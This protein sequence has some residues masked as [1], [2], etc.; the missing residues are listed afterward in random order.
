MLMADM[1]KLPNAEFDIMKVVWENDP[2]ITTKMILEQL[3]H[4]RD[5]KAQTVISLMLR[6][7]ERGFLRTEK[8]GKERTFYPLIERDAYLEFETSNFVNLYH[9]NS[10]LHLVNTMY[11]GKALSDADIDELLQWA[12]ERSE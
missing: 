11:H 7:V 4:E 5:W 3:G 9:E 8:K 12:R 1:K 2:P 6:L 10:L